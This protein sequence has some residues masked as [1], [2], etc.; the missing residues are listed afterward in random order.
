MQQVMSALPV[1]VAGAAPPVV[2]TAA[3]A[4]PSTVTDIPGTAAV[5]MFTWMSGAALWPL[6]RERVGQ[7]VQAAG[8]RGPIIGVGGIRSAEQ[9][10]ELLAIGCVAVQ[11][12][13]A[14]IFEGPGLIRRLNEGLA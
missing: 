11:V 12:Y 8:G 14:M 5:P 3:P 13:S 10:R 4:P 9:A 1:D 2:V 7:V 6:A